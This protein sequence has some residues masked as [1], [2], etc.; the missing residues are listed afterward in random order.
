MSLTVFDVVLVGA[1]AQ[2]RFLITYRVTAQDQPEAEVM[3]RASAANGGF[4]VIGLGLVSEQGE[5]T[6]DT[7]HERRVLGSGDRIYHAA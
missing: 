5:T 6:D 7:G 2:G 3:A 4:A 1:D